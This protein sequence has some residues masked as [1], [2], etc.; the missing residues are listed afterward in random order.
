MPAILRRLALAKNCFLHTSRTCSRQGSNCQ[1]VTRQRLAVVG[2]G[3]T[4]IHSLLGSV[5]LD[6]GAMP[7]VCWPVC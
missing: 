1:A 6:C 4:S 7:A 2:S 3:C 5:L